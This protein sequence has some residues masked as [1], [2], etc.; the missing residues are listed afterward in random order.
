MALCLQ[1][2]KYLLKTLVYKQIPSYSRFSAAKATLQSPMSV[3]PLVIKT[4][5]LHPSSIILHNSF[6]LILLR[7]QLDNNFACLILSFS[8][9]IRRV[10]EQVNW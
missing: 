8:G 10:A 3:C 7:N 1:N 4:P 2:K 6:Q 5:R 9:K